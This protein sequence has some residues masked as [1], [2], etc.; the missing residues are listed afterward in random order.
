[1]LLSLV[2]VVGTG[3][4]ITLS[5]SSE[6]LRSSYD[7]MY[8]EN[9]LAHV[10]MRLDQPRPMLANPAAALGAYGFQNVEAAEGRLSFEAS[11]EWNDVEH[12]AQLVGIPRGG[13]PEVNDVCV[14]DGALADRA[15][16]CTHEAKA[17]RGIHPPGQ[18]EAAILHANFAEANGVDV[19][20]RL[21][22]FV[23]GTEQR[24]RVADLGLNSEFLLA[25]ANL[26]LPVPDF[27]TLAVMWVAQDRMDSIARSLGYDVG[28]SGPLANEYGIRVVDADGDGDTEPE[29]RDIVDRIDANPA[30]FADLH[31]RLVVVREDTF[32]F[33]AAEG[34]VEGFADMSPIVATL[35][36]IIGLTTVSITMDRLVKHDRG[37]I[38]VLRSLGA[39]RTLVVSQYLAL[40]AIIG[41]LG[42]GIG[43][44]VG[45]WGA[46]AMSLWYHDFLGFPILHLL[47]S[48]GPIL[49]LASAA[50]LASVVGGLRA[51]VRG[52]RVGITSALRPPEHKPPSSWFRAVTARLGLMGRLAF[53]NIVRAKGR[54]VFTLVGLVLA[55][56]MT[57][58]M[59][60]MMDSIIVLLDEA[61]ARERWD[62][63][64]T[65][66]P[67]QP[68][69][70]V[71]EA[72]EAVGWI[73]KVEPYLAIAADVRDMDSAIR[74]VGL[75]KDSLHGLKAL[76]G[77][78]SLARSDGFVAAVGFVAEYEKDVGPL[79]LGQVIT[80]TV[81]GTDHR[82]RFVG[83]NEEFLGSTVYM[84]LG[85][86]QSFLGADVVSS[87]YVNIG[88]GRVAEPEDLVPIAGFVNFGERMEM[89]ESLEESM[90][91]SIGFAGIF[92]LVGVVLGLVVVLNTAGV[93]LQERAMEHGT[94]KAL[95]F[96]DRTLVGVLALENLVIGIVAAL[97]GWYVG[98]EATQALLNTFTDDLGVELAYNVPWWHTLLLLLTVVVMAQAATLA[99]VRQLRTLDLPTIVK[100]RGA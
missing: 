33:I 16:A 77:D 88:T 40:S 1:M 28:G 9:G 30:R 44:L 63:V 50:F 52:A 27:N 25:S 69:D 58:T 29:G 74:I 70:D 97:V 85:T 18:R 75:E 68:E 37:M 31:L 78:V 90:G 72:L 89:E 34:D 64:A 54:A 99:A 93:N 95:G 100:A 38:G 76:E 65:F 41:L 60:A 19:G 22:L 35:A 23:G 45:L 6:N 87:A 24:F 8:E 84:P 67:P 20:D 13:W 81:D 48:W 80:L 79:R 66:S 4:S 43:V 53:R 96:E 83:V 36:I 39:S 14:L 12:K 49:G 56:L 86:V 51:A 92:A 82:V 17:E 73:T 2:I 71:R 94:L 57:F 61:L 15:F 32:A 62:A 5:Q 47:T 3:M 55:M 26:D 11:F 91:A 59:V 10:F 21:D 46:R 7:A 98:F 42:A